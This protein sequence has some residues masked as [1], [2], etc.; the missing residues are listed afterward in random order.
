VDTAWPVFDAARFLQPPTTLPQDVAAVR[1][2]VATQ[3]FH[4]LLESWGHDPSLA[5]F[6][7][8]V[9]HAQRAGGSDRGDARADGAGCESWAVPWR[10]DV[11][12]PALPGADEPPASP[13]A[14]TPRPFESPSACCDASRREALV[15]SLPSSGGHEK[16]GAANEASPADCASLAAS[17]LRTAVG[18]P[19]QTAQEMIAA[20]AAETAAAE[21]GA[22]AADAAAAT[23]DASAAG[24]GWSFPA[25]SLL[26][27]DA[28]DDA[29]RRVEQQATR[30]FDAAGS[31]EEEEE[32]QDEG[33]TEE[34]DEEEDNTEEDETEAEE[35]ER[36]EEEEEEEDNT[37]EDEKEAEEEEEEKRGKKAFPRTPAATPEG[38]RAANLSLPLSPG[39]AS[40]CAAGCSGR[41]RCSSLSPGPAAATT[42]RQATMPRRRAQGRECGERTS[43]G[44]C[45]PWPPRRALRC[46]TSCHQTT[47]RWARRRM[48]GKRT[49]R[50][51]RRSMTH[52]KRTRKLICRRHHRRRRF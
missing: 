49:R 5:F 9:A 22:I 26:N 11:P 39:A 28:L 27:C 32:G 12:A 3:S 33:G 19:L 7:H 51:R 35:E 40:S 17:E 50:M 21:E 36:E 30:A 20:A 4:L 46:G 52:R 45:K 16:S 44:P 31:S 14:A 43:A 37:E 38:L 6:R 48:R 34:E 10:L 42:R 18:M 41:L 24:G 23:A 15:L 47:R 8:A 25:A 2:I 1:G 29:A 13:E